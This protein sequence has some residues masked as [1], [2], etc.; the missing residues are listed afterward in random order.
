MTLA[1]S[2]HAGET[3][4]PSWYLMVGT[5]WRR[6]LREGSNSMYQN[7]LAQIWISGCRGGCVSLHEFWGL[8]VFCLFPSAFVSLSVR[9]LHAGCPS[10]TTFV[11][12]CS[13]GASP[14]P[15]LPLLQLRSLFFFPFWAPEWLFPFFWR[16]K[17]APWVAEGLAQE[18]GGLMVCLGSVWA[19]GEC[20]KGEATFL[21]SW[22]Y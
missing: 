10:A 15:Q 8:A 11:V 5:F 17:A 18:Q 21:F 13:L 22:H 1:G 9:S 12:L 16:E 3:W 19:M 2:A 4:G 7:H 6:S 14:S 20:C